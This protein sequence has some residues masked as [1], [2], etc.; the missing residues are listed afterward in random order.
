MPK[1]KL[2]AGCLY[3]GGQF[4]IF[5]AVR[6]N[7]KQP[8]KKFLLDLKKKEP[9]KFAKIFVLIKRFADVGEI[10]NKEQ[11]RHEREGIYA[12]KSFQV[13]ILGFYGPEGTFILTHGIFKKQPKLHEKEIKKAKD[14][15]RYFNELLG[16][17]LI[18]F[19]D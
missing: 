16:K 10:R 8:A 2:R 11:F 4:Q 15:R 14:I 5:Y 13:R 7:G 17:G 19:D 6:E 18:I 3:N 1:N 12:F 9:K